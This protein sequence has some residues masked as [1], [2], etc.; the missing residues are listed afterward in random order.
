MGWGALVTL[1]SGPAE[2]RPLDLLREWIDE[3]YRA[4]APQAA[5]GHGADPWAGCGS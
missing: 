3:T 5:C 1:K 4:V 2:A